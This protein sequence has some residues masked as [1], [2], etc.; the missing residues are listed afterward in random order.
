MPAFRSKSTTSNPRAPFPWVPKRSWSSA[1][2]PASASLPGLPPPSAAGPAPWV[3]LLNA[4][5]KRAASLARLVPDPLLRGEGPQGRSVGQ[6]HQRG[7]VLRRHQDRSRGPAQ[8]TGARGPGGVQRGRPAPYRSQDRCGLQVRAQAHRPF[9]HQQDPG[10]Q[11]RRRNHHHLGAGDAGRGR[12]HHPRHGR[13]R[14]G[15]VDEPAPEGKPPRARRHQ[16]AYSYIGPKVTRPVYSN[17]TIGTAKNHLEATARKHRRTPQA[18]TAAAP[19]SRSTRPWSR[20]PAPPSPSFP[21]TSA[22]STRS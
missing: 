8:G 18:T 17:G 15:N 3:W 4:R 5:R 2:P 1:L 13:R 19:S 16:I 11:H 10:L 22:C 14:L 21:S 7:R 12:S 20:R 6:E 9:L